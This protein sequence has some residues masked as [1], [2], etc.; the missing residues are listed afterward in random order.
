MVA[1]VSGPGLVT[2][3][4][5]PVKRSRG[6]RERRLSFG[7]RNRGDDAGTVV[8]PMAALLSQVLGFSATAAETCLTSLATLGDV[9]D[10]ADDLLLLDEAD[11]AQAGVRDAQLRALMAWIGGRKQEF[12]SQA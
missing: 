9:T 2:P 7:R 5:S 6:R 11:L 10:D 12:E 3:L 1:A 8:L 4:P